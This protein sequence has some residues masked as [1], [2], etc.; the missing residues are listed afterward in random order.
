INHG[1]LLKTCTKPNWA[2]MAAFFARDGLRLAKRAAE[3]RKCTIWGQDM[4][5]PS[6]RRIRKECSKLALTD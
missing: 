6:E 5:S 4:M 1:D 2:N 3:R